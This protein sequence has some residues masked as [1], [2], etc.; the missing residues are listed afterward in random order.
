MVTH[1]ISF[2]SFPEGPITLQQLT[3]LVNG[4]LYDH[5]GIEGKPV[6]QAMLLAG[7]TTGTELAIFTD[8]VDGRKK[9]KQTYLV[10]G[11][12]GLYL[13]VNAQFSANYSVAFGMRLKIKYID[14]T[15][16]TGSI[17][18][19]YS[20][21]GYGDVYQHPM[22]NDVDYCVEHITAVNNL[23]SGSVTTYSNKN[24]LLTKLHTKT[25]SRFSL[26]FN[27]TSPYFEFKA[28]DI[29]IYSDFYVM[30]SYAEGIT[31]KPLGSF[32]CIDTDPIVDESHRGWRTLDGST[33][34]ESLQEQLSNPKPVTDIGKIYSSGV[35]SPGTTQPLK[36]TFDKTKA[37]EIGSIISSNIRLA[38]F[39]QND[40]S[41][42]MNV[43]TKSFNGV[44]TPAYI[45]SNAFD[46]KTITVLPDTIDAESLVLNN[47][48]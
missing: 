4:K 34:T 33:D 15:S 13:T 6:Q 8:P 22:F 10:D 20:G 46:V 30:T 21:D 17:A 12:V 18:T 36:L 26:G 45:S 47:A 24:L 48:P 14:R 28:G 39:R 31:Y 7:V 2:D 23:G 9:L 19:S 11:H 5:K 42:V 43:K 32:K 25:I 38:T 16:A 37:E 1:L 27:S 44:S 41:S 35:S 3:A 40:S 29:A